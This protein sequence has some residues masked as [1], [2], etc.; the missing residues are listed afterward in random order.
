MREVNS[1]E[2]IE[3]PITRDQSVTWPLFS[4]AL[5]RSLKCLY[6][7][8]LGTVCRHPGSSALS[9]RTQMWVLV[10]EDVKQSNMRG[11]SEGNTPQLSFTSSITTPVSSGL[12]SS[13]APSSLRIA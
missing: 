7:K 1:T 2:V 11:T 4:I 3:M 13:S 8:S 6:V 5:V 9:E 12:S 10:P